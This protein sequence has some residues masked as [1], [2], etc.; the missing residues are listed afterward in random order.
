[1]NSISEA[2]T[3]APVICIPALDSELPGELRNAL[4]STSRTVIVCHRL[5]D[6]RDHLAE[7]QTEEPAAIFVERAEHTSEDLE[8]IIDEA[9]PV[10]VVVVASESPA[11]EIVRTIRLGVADYLVQPLSVAELATSL[12]RVRKLDPSS[13]GATVDPKR[14]GPTLLGASP[15]MRSIKKVARHVSDS[16]VTVLIR[17]ESGTGKE[18]LARFIHQHSRRARQPFVKVNCAALPETLVEAELF[19]YEKG[20]F[21]GAVAARPG[22]FEAASRGTIFLDEIAEMSTGV[23]AKLLQVLQD[24]QFYRLGGRASLVTDAKI[25]AATNRNLEDRL[26]TGSFREDLYFRLNVIDVRLPPLR[27]RQDEI[28]VFISHFLRRFAKQYGK[29]LPEINERLRHLLIHDRWPGNIRELENIIKRL[30]IL[31]DENVII[32]ELQHRDTVPREPLSPIHGSE[33]RTPHSDMSLSMKDIGRRAR[34]AAQ[35]ELILVTLAETRWN[36]KITARTLGVSYK[37]LLDKMKDCGINP[38]P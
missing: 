22:K 24:G 12:E 17:G 21:T 1:M 27:E 13:D 7:G 36:R 31:G 11:N 34:L 2:R 16:D 6:L 10:P 19:G 3:D 35:R 18:V 33:G 23:Q 8:E 5:A 26:K 29:P 28:S 9:S 14:G 25:L 38:D 30:V 15:I 37:T 20:A 4:S 32:Q